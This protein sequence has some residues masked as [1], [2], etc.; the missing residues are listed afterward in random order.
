MDEMVRF[1]WPCHTLVTWESWNGE[2]PIALPHV[3]D[4]VAT[5]HKKIATSI[6]TLPGD[7]EVRPRRPSPPTKSVLAGDNQLSGGKW[8]GLCFFHFILCFL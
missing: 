8:K 5:Q 7:N 6:R 3:R 4:N 2:N 1:L